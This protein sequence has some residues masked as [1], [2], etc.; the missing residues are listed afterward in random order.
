MNSPGMVCTFVNEK[1]AEMPGVLRLTVPARRAAQ[2]NAKA[3]PAELRAS[4]W[5]GFVEGC[6]GVEFDAG[7]LCA[8]AQ[9]AYLCGGIDGSAW[10]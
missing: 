6:T 9:V 2:R 1:F 10:A 5:V 7:G 3:F 8:A 4:Y